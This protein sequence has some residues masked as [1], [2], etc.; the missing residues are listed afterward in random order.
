[1]IPGG[2]DMKNT[3]YDDVRSW[4]YR[5]A[6]H[7]ELS[8]WRFLFEEDS[9]EAVVEALMFYQ[10]KDGGFGHA[11]EADNWNP[12]STP[13]TTNHAIKLL[14][15]INFT[16]MSHPIY[17]GIWKYLKSGAAMTE[18]GWCFTIP[19]NDDY[20]HAPWWNYSE[21]QNQK[22]YYGVTAEL[23]AF[24]LKYGDKQTDICKRA[25]DFAT[26]ILSMLASDV[27]FG[28]M[29]LEGF[30]QL[31]DT[32]KQMSVSG[33]DYDKLNTL[34]GEKIEKAI[35]HDISK[36][37]FYSVR[38]SNF[39]RS[40]ESEYYELNKDIMEKELDYIIETK[41]VDDVWG[42]TWTWF[43]NMQQYEAYFRVSENWWK[44]FRAIESIWLLKRFGRI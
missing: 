23:S 33:F 16:D 12:N 8:L 32:M 44:G 6:R 13:I 40:P 30:L 43:D 20:P 17:Q 15:Q 26:N 28:D 10:N 29:G 18:Y 39:I 9:K 42:I 3:I 27:P 34:M 1:M 2:I 35:E 21:E 24:I 14:H 19:S 22:E 4:M 41:P 31:I 37:Q 25:M 7:L 5:N 36:W 38:P 11:L